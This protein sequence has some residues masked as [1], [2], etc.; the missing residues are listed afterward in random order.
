MCRSKSS[1][2]TK[3]NIISSVVSEGFSTSLEGL[4]GLTCGYT[5]IETDE[6]PGTSLKWFVL[7]TASTSSRTMKFNHYY[8]YIK[9]RSIESEKKVWLSKTA[10]LRNSNTQKN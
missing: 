9:L 8:S 5:T 4:S 6:I 7:K 1:Y 3:G 2:Q 10:E